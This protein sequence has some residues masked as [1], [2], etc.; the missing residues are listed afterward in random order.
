M[1]DE[2]KRIFEVYWNKGRSEGNMKFMKIKNI[3]L[4]LFLIRIE[5]KEVY[6]SYK[7]LI[8]SSYINRN[9]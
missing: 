9:R 1:V 7:D 8:K 4:I 2:E 5:K 6:L 3:E